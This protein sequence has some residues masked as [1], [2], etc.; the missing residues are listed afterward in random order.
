MN[1]G[2]QVNSSQSSDCK[3]WARVCLGEKGMNVTMPVCEEGLSAS[4]EISEAGKM[5]RVMEL[6]ER[7]GDKGENWVPDPHAIVWCPL[8]L[9]LWVLLHA[10]CEMDGCVRSSHS[11]FSATTKQTSHFLSKSP[12]HPLVER[13]SGGHERTNDKHD[14]DSKQRVWHSLPYQSC[15]SDASLT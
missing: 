8:F 7:A 3:A 6:K 13:T 15:L 2:R 4:A 11:P 1:E 10:I 5:E 12:Q 14:H 9:V